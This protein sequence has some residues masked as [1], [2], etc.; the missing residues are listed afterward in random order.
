[1]LYAGLDLSR[2]KLDVHVLDEHGTTVEAVAVHPDADALRTLA[3]RLGPA[4]TATPRRR[5]SQQEHVR[6]HSTQHQPPQTNP[7]PSHRPITSNIHQKL[8]NHSMG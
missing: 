2:R 4:V 3:G 7:D 8:P 1:M 6:Q 5:R